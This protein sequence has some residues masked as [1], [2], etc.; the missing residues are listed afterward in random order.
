MIQTGDHSAEEDP[1]DDELDEMSNASI[2]CGYHRRR[3]CA[4]SRSGLCATPSMS[5]PSRRLELS[6]RMRDVSCRFPGC[7]RPA[8]GSRSGTDL[9]HTVPWPAGP[10][11]AS[12][13]AVL[14][15][16]HHRVK[17]SPG[18]AVIMLETGF[19]ERTTPG[20]L[21][22]TTRPWAYRDPTIP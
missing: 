7:R 13:L 2:S 10:T 20:G 22:F 3:P 12:N 15:R 21:T 5:G 11:E 16:H 9:D 14:C 8:A 18:W 4:I 1:E 17:H 19:L 6:V